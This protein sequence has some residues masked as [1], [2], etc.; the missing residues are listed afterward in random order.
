MKKSERISLEAAKYYA[1]NYSSM[2]NSGLS[3]FV[4]RRSH[5]DLENNNFIRNLKKPTILELGAS[6]DL[7]RQYVDNDYFSYIVSDIDPNLIELATKQ[8][9]KDE[10]VTFRVVDATNTN[11]ADSSFDR[12]IVTC[13][14]AHMRFP[15]DVLEEWRRVV[16]HNGILSFYAA[17]EPSMLLRFSRAITHKRN[18]KAHGTKNYDLL[19]YGQHHVHFPA[20]R[21]FVEDIFS[22]DEINKR[23][24]PFQWL[25]WNFSLYTV[26]HIKVRK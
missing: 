25:P 24:F 4:Y 6:Q 17:A 16:K 20:I 22:A 13:L 12:V 3:G 23:R 15:E 2:M 18:A 9:A 14:I 19:Q 26:Y 10:R 11:F 1:E 7:H 5:K 21:T 8:S